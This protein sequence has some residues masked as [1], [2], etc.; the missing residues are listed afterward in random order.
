MSSNLSRSPSVESIAKEQYYA[1]VDSTPRV[2]LRNLPSFPAPKLA[3]RRSPLISEIEK[4]P[5]R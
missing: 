5:S 2:P 4:N 3:Y 1:A